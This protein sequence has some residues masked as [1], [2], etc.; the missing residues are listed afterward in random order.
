MRLR[1]SGAAT[2][3]STKEVNA[4][5]VPPISVARLRAADGRGVLG[6]GARPL[7]AAGPDA[8][9]SADAHPGAAG[10]GRRALRRSAA[11]SSAD[12]DA[13]AARDRVQVPRYVRTEGAPDRGRAAGRRGL[14][15]PRGR[16]ALRTSSFFARWATS[17]STSAS[18]DSRRPKRGGWGS[19]RE[20]RGTRRSEGDTRNVEEVSEAGRHGGAPRLAGRVRRGPLVRAGEGR[21]GGGPL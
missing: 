15:R 13:A 6:S 5:D 21:G 1:P 11:A 2:A 19:R 18:W 14:Q 8:S 12:P 16:H 17:P 9:A 10:A 4:D 7:R 3:P 20:P